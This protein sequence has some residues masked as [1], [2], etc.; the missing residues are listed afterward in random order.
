M[1]KQNKYSC[2]TSI[3]GIKHDCDEDDR[4]KEEGRMEANMEDDRCE[5]CEGIKVRSLP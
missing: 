4:K 5:K 2:Y 1:G 3:R